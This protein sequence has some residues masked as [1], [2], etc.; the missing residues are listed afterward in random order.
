MNKQTK[1]EL[2]KKLKMCSRIAKLV[3]AAAV[4][5][6]SIHQLIPKEEKFEGIDGKILAES[7]TTVD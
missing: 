5:A 3:G 2:T 4:M 7:R 1:K 6:Y